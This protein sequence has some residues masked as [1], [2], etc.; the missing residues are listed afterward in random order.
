LLK[1]ISIIR[2]MMI[3]LLLISIFIYTNGAFESVE[4]LE[5][6]VEE[7]QFAET[8]DTACIDN[9]ANCSEWAK[10]GECSKNPGY[11]LVNCKKSCK[12]AQVELALTT[13]PIVLDGQEEENVPKTLATCW[14]TARN[15]ANNAQ[16]KEQPS[17]IQVVLTTMPI[18][19]GGQIKENV[20]KTL[21]TCW[22]IAKNLANNAL[23]E[24]RHPNQETTY[25]RDSQ[26]SPLA[27][28]LT[29]TEQFLESSNQPLKVQILQSMRA[30][31]AMAAETETCSA[32]LLEDFIGPMPTCTTSDS[33][34]SL[35]LWSS[36]WIQNWEMAS[37]T[38]FTTLEL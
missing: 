5:R 27:D 8:R 16:M 2:K 32:A 15:H 33:R 30:H 4:L 3:Y 6:L 23:M 22:L 36:E 38:W 25:A 21:A 37:M 20:P 1:N 26:L 29:T 13:M 28:R 9:N 7:T 35:T 31:L 18:V 10:R 19:L 34:T 24:V 14:L 11:M 12:N 17:P